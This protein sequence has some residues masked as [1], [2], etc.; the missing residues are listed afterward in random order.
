M[1][2]VTRTKFTLEELKKRPLPEGVDAA[3]L[4]VYLCDEDFDKIFNMSREQFVQQP[5]WIKT[6][7]KKQ[8]GL[9]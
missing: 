1:F 9:F 6:K 5:I 8:A 7:L 3:K 4:E 2:F